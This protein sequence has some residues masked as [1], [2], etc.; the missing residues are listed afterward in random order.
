MHYVQPVKRLD[1]EGT[2]AC[3]L[4]DGLCDARLKLRLSG[5]RDGSDQEQATATILVMGRDDELFTAV[6]APCCCPGCMANMSHST[7]S[8]LLHMRTAADTLSH[9]LRRA[10]S[11]CRMMWRRPW[12]T[13]CDGAGWRCAC[14]LTAW[15]PMPADAWTSASVK[16]PSGMGP[17]VGHRR[18]C[19]ASIAP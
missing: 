1:L 19:W 10:H 11:V 17:K 15:D 6:S 18:P 7:S 14:S 2:G 3:G 16:R 8:A 4:D 5:S 13:W 9:A 12:Q